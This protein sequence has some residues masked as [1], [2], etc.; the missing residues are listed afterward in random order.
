MSKHVEQMALSYRL[1]G[2]T[3][4]LIRAA[5][6]DPNVVIVCANENQCRDLQLQFGKHLNKMSKI[7]R[8]FWK[9]HHKN[10]MPLFI[11][12]SDSAFGSNRPMVFDNYAI[13]S[14]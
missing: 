6:N 2:S 1:R 8:W 3:T 14:N 4:Y 5:L 11:S 13:G 12:R 10:V 9:R 7:R